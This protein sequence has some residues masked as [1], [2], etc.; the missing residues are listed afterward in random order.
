MTTDLHAA[1]QAI[2]E[3]LAAGPTVGPWQIIKSYG[4]GARC[5]IK[6]GHA[7]IAV[8]SVT[9]LNWEANAALIAA[10]N[11]EAITTILAAL[12]ARDAEIAALREDAEAFRTMVYLGIETKS[13]SD[14]VEA[15]GLHEDRGLDDCAA[16][17]KAIHRV[18]ERAATDQP[19]PPPIY[20]STEGQRIARQIREGKEGKGV[21]G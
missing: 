11:P 15:E 16:M 8:P 1:T 21:R 19:K 9:N 12:E 17:R 6:A 20:P 13:H 5:S 4:S 18:A 3:A 2:R 7:R 14:T 10:C